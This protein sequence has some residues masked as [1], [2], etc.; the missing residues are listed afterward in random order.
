M[1]KT[2]WKSAFAELISK[3]GKRP[4]PLEYHNL[5]ELLVMVIL[6]AQDSDR[7]INAVAPAF[8][9]VYPNLSSLV[10]VKEETLL[11]YLGKVRGHRKKISWI[12]G[13]AN[14]LKDCLSK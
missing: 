8:F 7:H 5:Y 12:V 1:A 10:G 6:S 2:D 14:S 3:Y 9:E 13:I 11:P 4:H